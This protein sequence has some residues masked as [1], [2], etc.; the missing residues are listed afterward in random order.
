MRTQLNVRDSDGTVVFTRGMP[1]G[2]SALTIDYAI[3]TSRP[4]LHIDLVVVDL[5]AAA[6]RIR[7]WCND[8]AIQILNVAGSRDSEAPGI[9]AEAHNI[10]VRALTK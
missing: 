7:G 5:A 6:S 9:G 2:G 8:E 1:S 3:R 10:L 4:V